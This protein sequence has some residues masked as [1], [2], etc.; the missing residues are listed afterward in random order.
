VPAFRCIKSECAQHTAIKGNP[1]CKDSW[2]HKDFALMKQWLLPQRAES[3]ES[4]SKEVKEPEMI[5]V[6]NH[7]KTNNGWKLFVQR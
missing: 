7:K 3:D 2:P 1:R 5:E 6:V 4:E